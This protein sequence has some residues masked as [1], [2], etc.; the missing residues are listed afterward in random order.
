MKL[1]VVFQCANYY[2]FFS[3]L[4]ILKNQSG[5]SEEKLLLYFLHKNFYQESD[6]DFFVLPTAGYA[7]EESGIPWNNK[8]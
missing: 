3:K 8:F 7:R 6:L 2:I 4:G 1:Y 5:S